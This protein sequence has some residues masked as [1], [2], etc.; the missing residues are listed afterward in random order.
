MEPAAAFDAAMPTVVVPLTVAPSVAGAVMAAPSV[1]VPLETLIVRVAVALRKVASVTVRVNVCDP[2][3]RVVVLRAAVAV[4]PV[5]VCVDTDLPSTASAKVLDDPD[6]FV[7]CMPIVVVPLTVAPLV[8]GDVMAAV[9]VLPPPP[10]PPDVV[11]VSVAVAVRP[12]ESVTVNDS[13]CV[14]LATVLASHP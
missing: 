2:F 8:A 12:V 9:I 11:T 5:T 7:T 10:V 14:P 1:P 3:E 13:V 6:A 4:V